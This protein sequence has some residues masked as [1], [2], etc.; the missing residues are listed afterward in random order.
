MKILMIKD[1]KGVGQRGSIVEVSD[2]Y[3]L[4]A[5]IPS[6]QAVQATPE[7]LAQ[8]EKQ[9]AERALIDSAQVAGLQTKVR[10]LDGKTFTIQAVVNE[11]GHLFKG[12]HKREIAKAIGVDED[13]IT[14]VGDVVKDAGEY[15]LTI[16]AHDTKASVVLVIAKK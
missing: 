11:K 6:G 14:G 2:G 15:A 10:A 12:M 16:Q 8:H 1:V 7:K 9:Q 3:A 4:N 5:L 13:M